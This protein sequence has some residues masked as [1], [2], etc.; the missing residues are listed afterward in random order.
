MVDQTLLKVQLQPQAYQSDYKAKKKFGQMLLI[1]VVMNLTTSEMDVFR[2]NQSVI[3]DFG[4]EA[5][6]FGK[7]GI[8]IRQSPITSS[9]EE[10]KGLM[11]EMIEGFSGGF[12]NS[13]WDYEEKMIDMISCKYAIK[14]NKKLTEIEMDDIVRKTLELEKRGKAT[15]P[16]GRPIKIEFSKQEVE[17]MFKR[18]V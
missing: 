7:D 8:I 15:C 13:V 3:E 4:F 5:E 6:E 18:I 14:A 11:A 1:P 17:K 10:I 9:D 16:H 2:E 12:K